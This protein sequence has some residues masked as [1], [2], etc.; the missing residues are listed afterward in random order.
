MKAGDGYVA[1]FMRAWAH[2]ELDEDMAAKVAVYARTHGDR[3]QLIA[4]VAMV[5]RCCPSIETKVVFFV[6]VAVSLAFTI[7][8]CAENHSA[9]IWIFDILGLLHSVMT[10]DTL[11]TFFS[12]WESAH[13]L[14]LEK[15]SPWRNGKQVV[16]VYNDFYWIKAANKGDCS[17]EMDRL[18]KARAAAELAA[19]TGRIPLEYCEFRSKINEH[20]P[21]CSGYVMSLQAMHCWSA[22][23]MSKCHETSSSWVPT[24]TKGSWEFYRQCCPE[25]SRDK[26]G[27]WMVAL[28]RASG[29]PLLEVENMLCKMQCA[30]IHPR[31][32]AAV[33]NPRQ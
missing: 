15:E 3:Q 33:C 8:V 32:V 21:L 28:S 7:A 11:Q 5:H 24:Q 12:S 18:E 26:F 19:S 29:C 9:G 30:K 6:P 23:G 25:P 17:K 27:A 13:Q 4:W 31:Q 1:S 14:L 20:C 2:G 16:D 22:I 10:A